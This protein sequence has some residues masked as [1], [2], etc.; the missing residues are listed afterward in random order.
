MHIYK[1]VSEA[2]Y[3]WVVM[4]LGSSSSSVRVII[5]NIIFI[6]VVPCAA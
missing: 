2:E 5:I 1:S 3:S 6:P 4:M